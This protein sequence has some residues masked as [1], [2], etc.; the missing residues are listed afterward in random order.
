[1]C[2]FTRIYICF[3]EYAHIYFRVDTEV[4]SISH[5]FWLV[6]YVVASSHKMDW[7]TLTPQRPKTRR[8]P[9]LPISIDILIFKSDYMNNHYI[10]YLKLR[11]SGDIIFRRN[12][13]QWLILL[14]MWCII[15]IFELLI[16]EVHIFLMLALCHRV[17]NI[18]WTIKTNNHI[19]CVVCIFWFVVNVYVYVWVW[20]CGCV[21]ILLVTL[22][23]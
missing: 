6:K 8:S 21:F 1:M 14:I 20:E 12:R 9:Y 16:F 3:R 5:S 15:S 17:R 22:Y 2:R 18:C 4:M 10:S 19:I 23:K 13:E 7:T 11:L